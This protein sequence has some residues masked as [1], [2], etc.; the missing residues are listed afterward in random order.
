MIT[1]MQQ[2]E[3]PNLIERVCEGVLTLLETSGVN[4]EAPVSG[5]LTVTTQHMYAAEMLPIVVTESENLRALC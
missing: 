5:V 4:S 1:L 2:E 3:R